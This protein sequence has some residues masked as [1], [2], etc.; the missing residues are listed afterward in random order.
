MLCTQTDLERER[1]GYFNA[2]T[3]IANVF[4]LDDSDKYNPEPDLEYYE[5][6][7]D[8]HYIIDFDLKPGLYVKLE[9]LNAKTACFHIDTF[10]GLKIRKEKS[11]LFDI[12][13]VCHP[14]FDSVFKTKQL[15]LI[16]HAVDESIFKQ[17]NSPPVRSLQVGFVGN[18]TLPH[19]NY[20]RQVLS[21]VEKCFEINDY[22]RSYTYL[23][24][25]DL[26]CRSKIVINVSRDD[27]LEDANLRC[28]E[29]MGA[30]ALLLTPANSELQDLGFIPDKH[31][32]EF[33]STSDL[34]AKIYFFLENEAQRSKVAQK[35]QRIVL[36]DHTY[37]KRAKKIL[38]LFNVYCRERTLTE[39]EINTSK[40]KY[41]LLVNQLE[42]HLHYLKKV[43]H[44]SP[45][46]S[47]LLYLKGLLYYS[48]RYT[49]K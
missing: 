27:Y 26:Y 36:S 24:L 23:E 31:Y 15:Q 37:F 2:F 34:I 49:F 18:T 41:Y 40:A 8:L 10:S 35:A 46:A 1:E 9:K 25:L 13:F 4:L 39:R 43:R 14:R 16:P 3:R 7:Y 44:S 30:G 28:F 47:I 38:E 29:A 11:R 12:T 45:V 22:R 21:A 6:K 32:I 17:F 48:F 42:L 5:R 19:Y 33:H 20:R